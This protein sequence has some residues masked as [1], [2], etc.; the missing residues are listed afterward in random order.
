M[1]G[2]ANECLIKLDFEKK[3]WYNKN[4]NGRSASTEDMYQRTS[5][6][7]VSVFLLEY[8]WLH[9]VSIIK[10]KYGIKKI[11]TAKNIH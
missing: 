2:F 1:S 10:C 7:T 4:R 5:L 9:F 11:K 6:C 3:L 8:Q